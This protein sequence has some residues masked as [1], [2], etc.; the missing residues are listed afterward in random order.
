VQYREATQANQPGEPAYLLDQDYFTTQ[1]QE[2]AGVFST[3]DRFEQEAGQFFQLCVTDHFHQAM[4]P[5]AA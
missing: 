1:Q 5:N 2:W 4:V 3:L